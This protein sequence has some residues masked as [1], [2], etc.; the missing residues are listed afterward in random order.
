MTTSL[1]ALRPRQALPQISAV[2]WEHP[3]DRAALQALRAVPGVDEVIRKV[4]AFLGGERGIRLLFQGNA[5]RLGPTQFPRL[6][7]MHN[8][9]ITTFDWPD[10]PELYVSQTPFFNAGAYGIDQPFIVIHSA[11]VE[12]LDDDE[13]RV[14]LSHELGH[15][16]SGHALYR[17]IAAIL[18][19]I[20]LGAL[21]VLAGLAVLPIRLA[22]LEWS[23]KSELSSDRAGLLGGQDVVAA[24]RLDMKMA[25]GA[26]G[27]GFAAELNV[28]A[29][30][31]QAHEYAAAGDGLDVVYKLLSTLALTHPMHT[32]RAAE[33]QRWVASGEYD[34]I[35]RGEYV[36]RGAAASDRPLR[37]DM[38]A[39]GSYYA[40]EAREIATQVAEAAKRAAERAKEAFR[41]AQKQSS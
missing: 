27:P 4:L 10:V 9:V 37:D 28:E 25:G 41:N 5:V 38:N 23:R 32:V 13:L 11:A 7:H 3:A 22:F 19:L 15:V 16:M 1:P 35:V 34:R 30:M 2:S 14:L 26:R 18:A 29:F 8:E 17:T 31:A 24:Q 6:W 40:G 21:P 20:S 12:L 33:L 36:R 39:A